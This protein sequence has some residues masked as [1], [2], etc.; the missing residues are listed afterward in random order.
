[1]GRSIIPNGGNDLIFTPPELAQQIVDYFDPFGQTPLDLT[2]GEIMNIQVMEPC[3]GQGAFVDALLNNARKYNYDN[4]VSWC[5][6]TEGVD[7]LATELPANM[8][9]NHYHW[10]VTNPPWSKFREFL[11]KSMQISDNVVFL[12]L[13]N[14]FFFKARFRDIKE[15]GFGFKEIV[16]IETPPKPWPQFGIQLGV[17]HLQKGYRG[18]T[19]F[20]HGFP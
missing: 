13:V 20:T 18:D 4:T 16:F 11:K 15:H 12:S 6:L 14:A 10:I 17:V 1:M 19:Q 8:H 3:K 7:F 2:S 9:Y 5:E